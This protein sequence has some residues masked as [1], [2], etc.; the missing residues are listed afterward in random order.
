MWRRKFFVSKDVFY[1]TG[2][3]IGTGASGL[4]LAS[5]DCRASNHSNIQEASLKSSK[6]F[7]FSNY[8]AFHQSFS[9]LL[10]SRNRFANQIQAITQSVVKHKTNLKILTFQWIVTN[11]THR[12]EYDALLTLKN[13][14]NLAFYSRFRRK[15]LE[16]RE[17][18]REET[19]L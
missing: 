8:E 19:V 13:S 7:V 1:R 5:V 12:I 10:T 17:E 14:N 16:N 9:T 2:N 18:T 4:Y 3:Q 11:T 6:I 15:I